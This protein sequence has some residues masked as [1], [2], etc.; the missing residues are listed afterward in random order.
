MLRSYYDLNSKFK[1]L[2]YNLLISVIMLVC[3]HIT[4]LF[5]HLP[6]NLY[7]H[8]IRFFVPQKGSVG[9]RI[10]ILCIIYSMHL[11]DAYLVISLA[12]L[13]FFNSAIPGS[14][15][16]TDIFI[17]QYITISGKAFIY[18]IQRCSSAIYSL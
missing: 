10:A 18:L 6:S 3:T 1:Q 16:M 7:S 17:W 8:L 11:R 14:D 4:T 13:P 5:F 9:P 2:A 15:W 12:V